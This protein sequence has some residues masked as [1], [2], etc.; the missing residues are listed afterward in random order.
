MT[1]V[2]QLA[3]VQMRYVNKLPE[4]KIRELHQVIKAF[5][6][7]FE[8]SEKFDAVEKLLGKEIASGHFGKVY[9]FGADLIIKIEKPWNKGEYNTRDGYILEELSGL[10]MIPQIY[11]YDVDNDFTVIQKIDGQ[12]CHR[13]N[14]NPLFELPAD[15]DYVWTENFI[16]ESAKLIEN[17]GWKIADA[18]AENCM[19]DRKGNFWI[20]DVGLFDNIQEIENGGRKFGCSTGYAIDSLKVAYR[21][22]LTKERLKK[23]EALKLQKQQAL[24][25]PE[26]VNVYQAKKQVEKEQAL[27][28]HIQEN[29]LN[30]KVDFQ[31]AGKAFAQVGGAFVDNFKRIG[32]ELRAV[33]VAHKEKNLIAD[34]LAQ[35]IVLP[36]KNQGNLFL[37]FH[38][39]AIPN[40]F[41]NSAV[42][43]GLKMHNAIRGQRAEMIFIDELEQPKAYYFTPDEMPAYGACKCGKKIPY[44]YS[45]CK[46]CLNNNE[47]EGLFF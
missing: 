2:V 30:F 37:N 1:K 32:D 27:E 24:K 9:D 5:R 17:R 38:H 11:I 18:H 35:P 46:D 44:R 20:V 7:T 40:P 26:I 3:G 16:K 4:G 6:D 12:T 14:K 25:L 22:H 8:M 33:A 19:I 47:F 43:R 34:L 31:E 29:P 10:P 15:F 21:G 28:K 36:E 42:E 45:K 13:Y 41:E 23:E 39:H